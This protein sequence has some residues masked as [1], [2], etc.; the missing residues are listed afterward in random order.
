MLEQNTT[1][2]EQKLH[3]LNE[4]L[5]QSKKL[6]ASIEAFL[7]ESNIKVKNLEKQI[8]D[9]Q[10]S[11]EQEKQHFE[12]KFATKLEQLKKQQIQEAQKYEQIIQN[13]DNDFT[14]LETEI[15]Y[16]EKQQDTLLLT[17]G[18]LYSMLGVTIIIK[19]SYS[20]RTSRNHIL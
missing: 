7:N 4:D 1:I 18:N 15:D 2:Y 11:F 17:M 10:E 5:S 9:Q 12:Q 8:A 14:V 13:F 20:A 19:S 3:T 16:I 6:T